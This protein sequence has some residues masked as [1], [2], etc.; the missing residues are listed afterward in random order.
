MNSGKRMKNSIFDKVNEADE[1]TK[2]QS[3]K[4][5]TDF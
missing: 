3:F 4:K 5:I 2:V 1:Y